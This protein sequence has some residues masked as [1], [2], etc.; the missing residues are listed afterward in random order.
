MQNQKWRQNTKRRRKR[1]RRSKR[2]E[3]ELREK[4]RDRKEC[5]LL[6]PAGE[7]K[8]V[9]KIFRS[10][11]KWNNSR[12]LVHRD[13]PLSPNSQ[14]PLLVLIRMSF[15]CSKLAPNL[16]SRLWSWSVMQT[17]LPFPPF[18]DPHTPTY[19]HSYQRILLA[20]LLSPFSHL[21]TLSLLASGPGSTVH[22]HYHQCKE[23]PEPFI[24]N[25]RKTTNEAKRNEVAFSRKKK[26][27]QESC[28]DGLSQVLWFNESFFKFEIFTN[29][30]WKR[31]APQVHNL[32]LVLQ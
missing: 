8:K 2:E 16:T 5:K 28:L 13:T 6:S 4:E 15:T 3:R 9:E 26:A 18:L 1:G 30:P 10:R 22:H 29:I 32:V 20:P 19:F 23:Y 17:P 7:G 12:L 25:P 27:T 14:T 21:S 31:T 11:K 24:D